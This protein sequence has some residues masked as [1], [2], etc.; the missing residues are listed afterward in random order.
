MLMSV[1]IASGVEE[2]KNTHKFET[3]FVISFGRL[4]PMNSCGIVKFALIHSR[5]SL[6]RC[7]HHKL[8]VALSLQNNVSLDTLRSGL[9]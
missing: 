7:S 2:E 8:F 3:S 6:T 1:C 4:R 9:G 5:G